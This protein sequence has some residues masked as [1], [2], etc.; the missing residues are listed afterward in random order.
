MSIRPTT[1]YRIERAGAIAHRIPKPSHG[2]KIDGST[3]PAWTSIT[4]KPEDKNHRNPN[5]LS[6][7]SVSPLAYYPSSA[8]SFSLASW[9]AYQNLFRSI[10]CAETIRD[11]L[12]SLIF[13]RSAGTWRPI[14]Y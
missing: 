14:R 4:R 6:S 1:I 12:G 2:I 13:D 10:P 5:K 11:E 8:G 7:C 3:S 9:V